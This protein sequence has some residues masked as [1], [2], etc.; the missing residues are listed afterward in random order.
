MNITYQVQNENS[1][2]LFLLQYY[3]EELSVKKC[4]LTRSTVE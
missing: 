2:C 1:I 4:A 3:D